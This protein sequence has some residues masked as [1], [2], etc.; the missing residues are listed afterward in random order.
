[1]NYRIFPIR[2]W[3]AHMLS[4]PLIVF[5]GSCGPDL[6]TGTEAELSVGS[7]ELNLTTADEIRHRSDAYS[8]NRNYTLEIDGE[9]SIGW[10]TVAPGYYS[11]DLVS[12]ERTE[13]HEYQDVT[14]RS[15]RCFD[16]EIT[17]YVQI[18]ESEY[19]VVVASFR[20][21]LCRSSIDPG[22]TRRLVE[23]TFVSSIRSGGLW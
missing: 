7:Q 23:G 12:I 13:H 4:V 22:P 21:E 2:R 3:C 5:L 1:M 20:G 19:G 16:G 17:P 9:V 14:Y 18:H 8:P 10:P 11:G 6:F 15:S